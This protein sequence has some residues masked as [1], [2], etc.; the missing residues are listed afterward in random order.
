MKLTVWAKR[1][2]LYFNND[3]LFY[4]LFYSSYILSKGGA[5]GGGGKGLEANWGAEEVESGWGHGKENGNGKRQ[6]EGVE[7]GAK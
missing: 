4:V 5:E 6:G 1:R 3:G 2:I 7:V